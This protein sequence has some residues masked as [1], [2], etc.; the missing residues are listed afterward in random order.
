MFLLALGLMLPLLPEGLF[1]S[2]YLHLSA[3]TVLRL[4]ALLTLSLIA[5]SHSNYYFTSQYMLFVFI[6]LAVCLF[7]DYLVF[8]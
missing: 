7:V 4:W 8:S 2:S 1:L 5:V 6:Y 3:E